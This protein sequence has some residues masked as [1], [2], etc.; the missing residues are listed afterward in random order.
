MDRLAVLVLFL[1]ACH[2]SPSGSQAHGSDRTTSQIPP[3][4]RRAGPPASLATTALAVGVA[5]PEIA[6]AD[7]AGTPWTLADARAKHTRVMLVF[8]RGDW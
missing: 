6:L 7:A 3:S 8:Y 4:A 2:A 1:A 5:A